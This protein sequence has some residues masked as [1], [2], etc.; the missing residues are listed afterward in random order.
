MSNK[1][2]LFNERIPTEN[3]FNRWYNDEAENRSC[4][5]IIVGANINLSPKANKRKRWMS[6][7]YSKASDAHGNG[8]LNAGAWCHCTCKKELDEV[9]IAYKDAIQHVQ[10]MAEDVG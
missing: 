7:T 3:F 1:N 4:K 9:K 2:H 6:E 5:T 8:T 10:T